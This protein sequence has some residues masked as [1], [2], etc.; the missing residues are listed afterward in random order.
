VNNIFYRN[1]EDS[2]RD[3]FVDIERH[4]I[5][6]DL[7][8]AT[9]K[10]ER[11]LVG[12]IE[13]A[14][15]GKDNFFDAAT[16]YTGSLSLYSLIGTEKFIIQGRALSFDNKDVIP[17]GVVIPTSGK[18]TIAIGAVDGLFSNQSRAIYLEDTVTKKL[19]NLKTK[20][21]TFNATSG[22]FNNRFKL[23]FRDRI[24]TDR[25][26]EQS[27]VAIYSANHQI[28]AESSV[29][30]ISELVVFDIV[31]RIIYEVKNINK[32]NIVI[33]NSVTNS[34]TLIVKTTLENGEIVTKKILL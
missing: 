10:S 6:L 30:K 1:S 3:S 33:D 13:G 16:Q 5:W 19:H 27:N 24:E 15:S 34:Q 29:E 4:R 18:Y 12:Y 26:I 20:P 25:N 9:S 2:P 7:I 21:Y 8:D 14:T 32:N 17:L 23:R 28:F 31:G 22:I 11:T